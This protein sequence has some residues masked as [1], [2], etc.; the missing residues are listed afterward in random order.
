MTEKGQGA[1]E[2]ANSAPEPGGGART[3][4][5][6]EIRLAAGFLTIL[7]VLPRADVAPEALAASFG[8]FP[9]VGFALG[10]MLAA[11]N[12][13]LT[14]LF[15]DALAAVLLVLTLAVLTG[16]VHVDALADT[17][18]ALGAGSDRRRA[19]EI[20][21]DSRIGSFGTAA[22]FFFL[23]CEIVAL[24]TMGEARRTA[25][26]WLAPGLARWAMVAVGWRIDYLRAEGAGTLLV[27]PGGDRNLALACAIAAIAALPIL[28]WRVL[29]AYAVA[30]AL[31]AALRAAYRRWLGGVTGDLVGAAGE[32]MELA[33]LLVMAVI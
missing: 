6:T 1:P 3:G 8:W 23:A 10:A 5:Y 12:L 29:L 27:G 2:R 9:L 15:G 31:A 25:A 22:I 4:V 33:V 14:P 17:A 18:D 11:E 19:L 24:A 20:M 13:L 7:P 21:R 16:A 28:S 26:L 30:G 32:L